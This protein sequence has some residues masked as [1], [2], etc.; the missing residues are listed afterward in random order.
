MASAW[1]LVAHCMIWGGWRGIPLPNEKMA[2]DLFMI[3]S[4]FLMAAN[5]QA[6]S[7]WEPL[8][9]ARNCSRFW[10]RRLFRIAP[11]YYVALTIAFLAAPAFVGGYQELQKLPGDAPTFNI[12][13]L[14][15]YSAGNF[16]L[17]LSFLFGIGPQACSSTM[18][19][20]WSL[21]LEMQFYLAF[22]LIFIVMERFGFARV[23]VLLAIPSYLIGNAIF[24]SMDFREFSFLPMKL[25]YFLAGI[26]LF[27]CLYLDANRWKR[28]LTGVC[29]FML[30]ALGYRYS[31]QWVVLPGLLAAMMLFGFLEGTGRTPPLVA[32]AINSIG[33]KFASDTSYSVYLFHGF[34][35]SV[36]GLIIAACPSL[37][38]HQAMPRT[39]AI[40][41]FT[42]VGT[43]AL[44]FV[45]YR[46]VEKPG[47]T[48]G[49]SI[50]RGLP[51]RS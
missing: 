37:L 12:D 22:P 23:A 30:V 33:V 40:L 43:Y 38:S 13:G 35:I 48:V 46:F 20:D 31:N 50:L 32:K 29:A 36:S 3:I 2:V 7:S 1:V 34:F 9:S 39:I 8:D 18:L 24:R 25:N 5:S 11:A 19:P 42:V 49:K 26:L 17:H 4:G 6:R 28:A 47:I 45:S 15:D 21:S 16:L 41:V 14:T 51:A 10:L 27:K 44:A